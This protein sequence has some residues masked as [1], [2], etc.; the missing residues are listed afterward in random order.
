MCKRH[1]Y[2]GQN[3]KVQDQYETEHRGWPDDGFTCLRSRPLFL[4]PSEERD[5]VHGFNVST[6][7]FEPKESDDQRVSRP[8]RRP[9]TVPCPDQDV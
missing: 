5:E 7:R 8:S 1:K 3:C 2:P 6:A 9:A 4:V